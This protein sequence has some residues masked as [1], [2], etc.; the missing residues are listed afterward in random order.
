ME[1]TR[2]GTWPIFKYIIRASKH[3]GYAVVFMDDESGDILINPG[4]QIALQHFWGQSGRGT[5]K[6]RQF[7]VK[8][9]AGYLQDKFSYGL[10]RWSHTEA[11][12]EL[13]VEF[14]EQFGHPDSWES[15]VEELYEKLD[16]LDRSSELFHYALYCNDDV[17]LN[18]DY[19]TFG[20][21]YGNH[22]V[23][24]FLKNFWPALIQHWKA[25]LETEPTTPTETGK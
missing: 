14:E 20:E 22:K 25:E 23:D 19:R 13:K 16:D 3:G 10:S 7:L 1:I 5:E 24:L 18:C 4:E 15:E 8:A 21:T 2:E 6:L 11:M 12:K 17:T 9:S